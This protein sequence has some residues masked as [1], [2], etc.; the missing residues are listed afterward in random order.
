MMKIISQVVAG[1]TRESP[2]EFEASLVYRMS[3][4]TTRATQRSPVS[5]TNKQTDK[6]L[7]WKISNFDNR[8]FP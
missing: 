1:G 5:K 4:R 8:N 3:S 2:C 6:N 7:I